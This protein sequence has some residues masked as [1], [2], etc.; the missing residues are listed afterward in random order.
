MLVNVWS[1]GPGGRDGKVKAMVCQHVPKNIHGHVPLQNWVQI[2]EETP[3]VMLN[4]GLSVQNV[5]VNDPS[6]P[7]NPGGQGVEQGSEDT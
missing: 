6:V 5:L 2:L 3:T 7:C 4:F 1:Q